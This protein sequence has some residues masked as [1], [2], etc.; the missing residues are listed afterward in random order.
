MEVLLGHF[1]VIDDVIVGGGGSDGRGGR[2][3]PGGCGRV[4]G[5]GGCGFA[6][7]IGRG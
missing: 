3:G 7:L 4:A 1:D 5:N 6:W 2:G